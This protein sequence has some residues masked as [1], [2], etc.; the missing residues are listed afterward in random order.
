M[1]LLSHK[2]KD[3]LNLI[4]DIQSSVIRG[5]L[6]LN[7]KDQ[8]PH[9]VWTTD[10]V[11]PY[12]A[13]TGSAYLVD[14]TVKAIETVGQLANTFLR[15]TKTHAELPKNISRAHCVLSSP[16]IFSQAR[17]IS[18]QFEKD[19]KIS[20]AHISEI[21]QTERDSLSKSGDDK[22]I[23]IEEKIFDVR[24]NGYSISI[25]DGRTAQ[26][27][28]ISFAVSLASK[29]II[30]LF[31]Q[32]IKKANIHGLKIDFHSSLLL[33]HIGISSSLSINEPYILAHIHGELTDIVVADGQTCIL[34]GSHPVGIRTIIRQLM[35][36]L[37]TSESAIDSMIG[38]Y[39]TN[40]LDPLHGSQDVQ[41]IQNAM[42]SWIENC[43]KIISV[44]PVKYKPIRAIISSRRHETLFKNSFS[45]GYP[46]LKT[47]L[48]PSDEI[49]KLATFDQQ[50]E[51]LRLTGLYSAAI[52]S[53]E[54]I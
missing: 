44:I 15:D 35:I 53:L 9:I 13:D 42:A 8:L 11:I 19:T 12:R 49:Y 20:R 31:T 33:Q 30:Q 40:Q 14:M 52:N 38:L 26:S 47:E 17:T 46:N 43:N 32:A 24:L 37:N 5:A 50:T 22:M 39:E 36:T 48:L 21:I 16:W 34:F 54:N 3:V 23:G 2:P 10:V 51:K 6:I 7:K 28:E 41:S 29:N 27:L 25:W 18:Q 4:I 1:S 45:A